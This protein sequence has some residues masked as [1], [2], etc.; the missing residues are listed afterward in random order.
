MYGANSDEDQ[1]GGET[2]YIRLWTDILLRLV[3]RRIVTGRERPE[4]IGEW[5]R[6]RAQ[7]VLTLGQAG[8]KRSTVLVLVHSPS[9]AN[10]PKPRT[11]F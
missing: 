9:D 5:F 1:A 7:E 10:K 6:G 11:Q 8:V 2:S 4:L 3:A